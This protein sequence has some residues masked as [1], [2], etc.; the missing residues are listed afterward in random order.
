MNVNGDLHST[1]SAYIDLR[2]GATKGTDYH[3]ARAYER[4]RRRSAKVCF[5]ISYAS[6]PP[7]LWQP[8]E[9]LPYRRR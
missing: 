5:L 2:N 8:E 3:V 7:H 1:V 6:T 9:S 4:V